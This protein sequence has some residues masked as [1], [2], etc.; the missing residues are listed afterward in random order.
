MEVGGG[1]ES[2]LLSLLED[3]DVEVG[4]DDLGPDGDLLRRLDFDLDLD[5][6]PAAGSG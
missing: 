6:F 2:L 3:E 4:V 5:L 1:K